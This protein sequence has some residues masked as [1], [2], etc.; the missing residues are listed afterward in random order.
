[1]NTSCLRGLSDAYRVSSD[2]YVP[3]PVMSRH[4]GLSQIGQ[5]CQC[6]VRGRMA[7]TKLEREGDTLGVTRVEVP[8]STDAFL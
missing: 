6:F 8:N 3:G 2:A 1:M 5:V 7:K 4:R